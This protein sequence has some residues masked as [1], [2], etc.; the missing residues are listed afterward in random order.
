M[1]S[2]RQISQ[3]ANP[4]ATGRMSRVVAPRWDQTAMPPITARTAKTIVGAH[5]FLRAS[6]PAHAKSSAL[7]T[8]TPSSRS[9]L[10]LWPTMLI[11]RSASPPGVSRMTSSA[12]ATVGESRIVIT[13]ATK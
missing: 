11:A 2:E 3:V 13:I 8:K 9:G 12:T 6:R 10:S 7:T 1:S 5:Q 4:T